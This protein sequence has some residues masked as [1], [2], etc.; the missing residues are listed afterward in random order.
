MII[1]KPFLE[2]SGAAVE[3]KSKW[4]KTKEYLLSILF[5]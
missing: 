2:A 3:N 4:K 1:R 5:R